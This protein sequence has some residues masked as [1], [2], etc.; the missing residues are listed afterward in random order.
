[1]YVVF[2]CDN[3]KAW[4]MA[5]LGVNVIKKF[6]YCMCYFSLKT[7]IIV[8]TTELVDISVTLR[9]YLDVIVIYFH[10]LK[11]TDPILT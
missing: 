6:V 2:Y 7:S 10:I 1:M 9:S 5:S 4:V 8:I 3:E 11:T